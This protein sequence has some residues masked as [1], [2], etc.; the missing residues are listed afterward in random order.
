MVSQILN[1][2]DDDPQNIIH[3]LGS[4]DISVQ[5]YE[6]SQ[7]MVGIRGICCRSLSNRGEYP[8]VVLDLAYEALHEVRVPCISSHRT[9]RGCSAVGARVE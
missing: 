8:S 4:V 9:W 1:H 2:P 3:M 6:N 5:P 7:R